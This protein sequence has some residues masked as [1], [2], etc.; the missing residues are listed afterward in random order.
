M[1][2]KRVTVKSPRTL[3]RMAD[4]SA[5]EVLKEV[6]SIFRTVRE[7]L[8]SIGFT[9]DLWMSRSLHSYISLTVSF[10]DRFVIYC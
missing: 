1:I 2:S 10:I 5:E 9:S 3:S 7:D 4:E 8:V 6:T